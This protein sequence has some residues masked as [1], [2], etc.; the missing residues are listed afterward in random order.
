[1]AD[2]ANAWT[3]HASVSILLINMGF[4]RIQRSTLGMPTQA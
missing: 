1:V 4:F 2:T 3:V